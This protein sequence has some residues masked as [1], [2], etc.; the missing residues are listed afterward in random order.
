MHITSHRHY[1]FKNICLFSYIDGGKNL[2]K[3]ASSQKSCS[4]R[5]RHFLAGIILLTPFINCIAQSFFIRN[6]KK[7]Y[8]VKPVKQRIAKQKIRTKRRKKPVSTPAISIS[9]S[10]TTSVSVSKIV[11]PQ[12]IPR[13]KPF[14]LLN[15][16]DEDIKE[17]LGAKRY[18]P[19]TAMNA[20]L[21]HILSYDPSASWK[22]YLKYQKVTNPKQMAL[23]SYKSIPPYELLETLAFDVWGD[24]AKLVN[25]WPPEFMR[26]CS[27]AHPEFALKCV[28]TDLLWDCFNGCID[29]IIDICKVNSTAAWHLIQLHPDN[30]YR[31]EA[32]LKIF[33]G[34]FK[35]IQ[36]EW[37]TK[38]LSL[39]Q[40]EKLCTFLSNCNLPVAKKYYKLLDDICSSLKLNPFVQEKVELVQ[41][42]L[43]KWTFQGIV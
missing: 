9:I 20:E 24:T 36:S 18:Q 35:A 2:C 15:D 28:D 21:L 5:V 41:K 38:T 6:E 25:Y 32:V 23:F 27:F 42:V 11:L 16:D 33:K 3:A 10:S 7:S 19:R 26:D 43:D 22:R 39:T 13:P 40:L 37:T 29:E 30:N 1:T 8:R 4:L 14:I 12:F 31:P 34:A 17:L